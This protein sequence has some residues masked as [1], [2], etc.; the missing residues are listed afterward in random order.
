MY[1]AADS[2]LAQKLS[3]VE[4]V[5]QVIV[6]G[7]AQ[8]AVRVELNPTAAE[9]LRH[10]PGQVR[11]ACSRSAN[12]NRPKGALAERRATWATRHHRSAVQGRRVPAADRRLPQRRARAA[13]ATW[14]R[15]TTRSRTCATPASPTA[16]PRCCSSSS[17][18]RRE[19]HR[20]R[21]PRARAAAAAAGL[22]PAGHQPRRRAGPHHTIRAS[23]ADVELTLHDFDRAGDPGGVRVPARACGP[24]IIPS[25]AVPLS[26][27]GTFGV[28]YLLG[29]SSTTCR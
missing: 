21:G 17:A 29:Y 3:Q 8:P 26:L 6:G 19:H 5:G 2:I 15:S 25:V 16:N 22:D 9:Q 27:V 12:A 4:G 13:C 24:R 10:R 1:D 23:V 7:G 20:H 18:S 11:D 28:M 14:P